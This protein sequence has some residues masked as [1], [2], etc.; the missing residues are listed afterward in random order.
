MLRRNTYPNGLGFKNSKREITFNNAG[1]PSGVKITNRYSNGTISSITHTSLKNYM[2]NQKFRKELYSNPGK[3]MKLHF[4]QQLPPMMNTVKELN[5]AITPIPNPNSPQYT[6]ISPPEYYNP[7]SPAYDP[8]SPKPPQNS[9]VYNNY[10]APSP[11]KNPVSPNNVTKYTPKNHISRQNGCHP[12]KFLYRHFKPDGSKSYFNYIMSNNKN[13]FANV[14]TV[15]RNI[16]KGLVKVGGGGEG[17]VFVGCIDKTCK[18]KV[19]VKIGTA[20]KSA[21][22]QRYKRN[23]SNAPGVQEFKITKDIWDKCHNK[24]PHIVT[25]YAQFTCRPDDAFIGWN[26]PGLKR[27]LNNTTGQGTIARIKN[28]ER[29]IISY[30]EF[31]NGG[32]LFDWLDRHSSS[33]TEKDL[34]AVLFQIIYTLKVIYET[35]PSF[36]HNDIHLENILVKTEGVPKTGTTKYS[37]FN[38]PNRGIFVGLGDFGWGHSKNHPNPR[39]VSGMFK[40]QGIMPNKTIRM[41][42]HFFLASALLHPAFKRFKET[43]QFLAQ[44]LGG[45]DLLAKNVRGT[46]ANWRLLVNNKRVADIRALLNSDYFKTYNSSYVPSPEPLVERVA[47]SLTVP[48]PRN[49]IVKNLKNL[50][51][52]SD[53]CGKSVSKKKGGIHAMSVDAMIKFIRNNGTT[54]AV[55]MLRAFKGKKPKRS[56]ACFIIKSFSKGRKLMGLASPSPRQK[57]NSPKVTKAQGP[58]NSK[59]AQDMTIEQLK[60]FIRRKGTQA[61]KNKLNALTQ[62]P[63]RPLRSKYM[64]VMRSFNAGREQAGP[65]QTN[66]RPAP[67]RVPSPLKVGRSRANNATRRVAPVRKAMSFAGRDKITPAQ[68]KTIQLM[69]NR[70]YNKAPRTKNTNTNVLREKVF[71]K[72]VKIFKR[73][74]DIGVKSG[75]ISRTNTLR[76]QINVMVPAPKATRVSPRTGAKIALPARANTRFSPQARQ[77]NAPLNMKNY[78]LGQT[79]LLK[80][81]GVACNS[82]SRADINKVLVRVGVDPKTVE[83]KAK[84]CL[85]IHAARAQYVKPYKT[86]AQQEK[87][88]KN[89]K[90][91]LEANYEKRLNA[92][93]R[94]RENATRAARQRSANARAAQTKAARMMGT[95]ASRSPVVPGQRLRLFNKLGL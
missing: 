29:V 90:N 35:V 42:L 59:R 11:K 7:R 76:N 94:A 81:N 43:R 25:P 47:N 85:L 18:N 4:G 57:K 10:K 66:K 53:D 82:M 26:Y 12:D 95:A 75:L 46:M 65:R 13:G 1:N 61:A 49:K 62:S 19:S 67:R 88:V 23:T 5:M 8:T 16:Q 78:S 3:F 79:G 74:R 40:H 37:N 55:S 68:R 9:P 63:S 64:N 39:V 58:V 6:P 89:W 45:E 52:R 44:A 14:L 22:G 33:L 56:Q 32:S 15:P 51:E 41:D 30:Y 92:A 72:S 87:N 54:A 28:S 93:A 84:A 34:R 83:T 77:I 80:I 21:P 73:A 20:M 2:R 50:N 38:V 36:R 17:V 70:L 27:A 24:S 31:F 60:N 71:K 69:A 86:K 91:S 48:S